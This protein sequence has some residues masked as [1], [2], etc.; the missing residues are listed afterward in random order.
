MYRIRELIADG[1]TSSEIRRLRSTLT[2]L[3][4]G[5]Y[6]DPNVEAWERYRLQCVETLVRLK[7]GAALTGPSAA[8]VREVTMLG[9]PPSQVYV[10]NVTPGRYA[11]AVRVL[12]PVPACNFNGILLST[13][14]AMIGHCAW[15]FD[16]RQAIVVADATLAGGLCE[17]DDLHHWA[18][19]QAR[20]KYSSRVRWLADN[21][22]PQADSPGETLTRLAV[23]GLGYDVVSQY[24]VELTDRLA[25]I[26]LLVDGT[27]VAIEFDGLVKYRKRG[28]AKVVQEHLRE[29]EL[30]ALGYTLVRLVWQQLDDLE[31]LDRRLR[32]A[33]AHP[34]H[35]RRRLPW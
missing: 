27:K 25:F 24:R 22:D 30:Q 28:L 8:A 2:P 31:Q 35:R 4:W 14:P 5:V 17:K 34:S 20:K 13:P 21:A 1:A 16:P 32:A 15:I 7:T 26:D 9:D 33:G 12:P 23:T 6:V 19:S 11:P 29:G 10:S 3:A 18:L